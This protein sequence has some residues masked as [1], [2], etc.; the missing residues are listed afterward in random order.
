[1]AGDHFESRK[2][3]N[4]LRSMEDWAGGDFGDGVHH[5]EP[6]LRRFATMLFVGRNLRSEDRPY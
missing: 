1:M 3:Q 6:L 2:T 5:G 4:F